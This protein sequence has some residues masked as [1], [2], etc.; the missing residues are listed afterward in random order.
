MPAYDPKSFWDEKARRAGA[1]FESAVCLDDPVSNRIIDRIQKR[2]VRLAFRQISGRIELGGKRVLDY[3]CGTGRWVD[4]FRSR[5]LEYAGVDLSPEMIRVAVRR[6]PDLEFAA[7]GDEG[8]QYPPETFDIICS[9]AVIH[10][11]SYEEQDSILR[12][13]NRTLRGNGFL[14]LFESI[15]PLDPGAFME[16]PRPVEDWKQLLHTLGQETLWTRRTRYFST[17]TIMNKLVGENRLA[18]VSNFAGAYLDPYLGG[19][20]PA[21][22]QTRGA[23]VFRKMS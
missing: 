3:G 11:N 6:F 23:M 17:R 15:G 2:L 20:L 12:G 13:L 18:A 19:F 14:L 10:H 16:F 8:L 22:L 9:I 1:D 5:G 4:F 21:R 7:L